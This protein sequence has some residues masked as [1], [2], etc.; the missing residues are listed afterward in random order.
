LTASRA[1]RYSASPFD[2]DGDAG[3]RAHPGQEAEADEQQPPTRAIPEAGRRGHVRHA[4][5]ADAEVLLAARSAR[6]EHA[7]LLEIDAVQ[8]IAALNGRLRRSR[9]RSGPRNIRTADDYR[10]VRTRRKPVLQ[11]EA[12]EVE[13]AL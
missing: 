9:L 7:D 3:C 2:D 13:L 12:D 10:R 6:I 5:L 1:G 4:L 8:D 11:N